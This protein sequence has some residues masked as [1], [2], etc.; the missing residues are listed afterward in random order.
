MN[1]NTDILLNIQESLKRIENKLET[2]NI[3]IESNNVIANKLS[4][5]IW[6][7]DKLGGLVNA[8]QDQR[9]SFFL[10]DESE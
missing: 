7:L 8:L 3:A 4:Q 1:S 5:F 6:V 10:Q 2:T 9:P